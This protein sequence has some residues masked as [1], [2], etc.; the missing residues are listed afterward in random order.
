MVKSIVFCSIYIASTDRCLQH[1]S[2][3]SFWTQTLIFFFAFFFFPSGSF[4][5]S[6]RDSSRCSHWTCWLHKTGNDQTGSDQAGNSRVY[7]NG[8]CLRYYNSPLWLFC[9]CWVQWPH[10]LN[11][12]GTIA[13]SLSSTFIICINCFP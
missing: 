10:D 1:K 7:S 9:A 4:S 2:H 5:I 6:R 3:P 12:H 11:R 13:K 8:P